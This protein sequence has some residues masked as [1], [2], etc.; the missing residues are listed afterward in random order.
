TLCPLAEVEDLRRPLLEH[1]GRERSERLA[2]L[3][4][5]V[6]RGLHLLVA[7]VADDAAGA[8]RTGT[9]LH[10]AREPADDLSLR[11]LFGHRRQ[12]LRLRLILSV[13]RGL[14]VED[15]LDLGGAIGRPEERAP[16]E[17]LPVAGT[18]LLEELIPGEEGAAERPS[19]IARGGLDPHVVE[20]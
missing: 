6:H 16:L 18:R 4:L 20:R 11:H 2:I 10:A 8:E 3:D 12:Q 19:R 17:V 1:A 14:G 7:G 5:E 15:G 13:T 9:E